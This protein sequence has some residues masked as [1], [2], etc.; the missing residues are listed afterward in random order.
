MKVGDMV[1]LREWAVDG[2]FKYPLDFSDTSE[3][4]ASM[5]CVQ[6]IAMHSDDL[7]QQVSLKA[8]ETDA[9]CTWDFDL[10]SADGTEKISLTFVVK[11]EEP[12]GPITIVYDSGVTEINVK[13]GQ[14][15]IVKFSS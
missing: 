6:A 9:D 12:E 15:I 13:V 7:Y 2:K 4:Q 11:Y 10:K 14:E 3:I 8:K 1:T 5:N